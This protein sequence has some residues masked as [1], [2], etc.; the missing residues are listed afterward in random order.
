VKY[1]DEF[2]NGKAAEALRKAIFQEATLLHRYKF[3]EFCG[4]HTHAIYRYGIPTLLPKNVEMVHGPGC[5]VCILP[6]ARIDQAIALSQMPKVIFC[7][8]GDMLRVPGTDRKSLLKAKAEGA[9]VRMIYSVDDALRIAEENPHKEVI[10]FAI[11][12]ETTTPPT[13]VA[14]KKAQAIKLYNFK[15]FCNHVLTPVAMEALLHTDNEKNENRV[16]ID[17]FVG[18]AHVSIIIGSQA[19][20]KIGSQYQKP[21]VISGFEPLDILHSILMLIRQLNEGRCEVEN[22]YTRAVNQQGNIISQQVMGDVLELRETFEWRGLGWIPQSALKIN[23]NYANFD[24]ENC[25]SLPSTSG[26]ETKGCICGSVLRGVKKPTEC[27]LFATVCTP[28]NPL[29]SCMVSSEGACAAVYAY[30]RVTM[31]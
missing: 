12:F 10:F 21:I 25:Y 22:Q 1:I 14:I 8:Y 28:E 13:A 15:V 30:G 27:K 17:G 11:G 29:G 23:A 4:G 2:R 3:M 5:P 7:S 20:E 9:D 26:K 18:P 6:M 31:E 19:Y 16:D 24:A